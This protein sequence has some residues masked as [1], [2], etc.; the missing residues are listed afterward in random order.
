MGLLGESQ[1]TMDEGVWQVQHHSR[2]CHVYFLPGMLGRGPWPRFIGERAGKILRLY[3]STYLQ[4]GR[5]RAREVEMACPKSH[6]E[7]YASV[8]IYALGTVLCIRQVPNRCL[9]LRLEGR[10]HGIERGP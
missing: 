9:L 6:M 3:I 5:L 2:A 1:E 4:M 7:H 8:C 10:D